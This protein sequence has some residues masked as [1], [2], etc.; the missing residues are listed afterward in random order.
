M[1]TKVAKKKRVLPKPGRKATFE[2]A[3]KETLKQFSGT[4]A[5]LAK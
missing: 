5:K 2:E 3:Q 4:F 1:S